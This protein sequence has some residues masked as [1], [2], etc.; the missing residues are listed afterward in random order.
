MEMGNAPTRTVRSPTCMVPGRDRTPT[1]PRVDSRPISWRHSHRKFCAPP[2][3]WKPT[4]SAPVRPRMIAA[5]HGICMNSSTGGNGMCRK[6]PMRRSGLS[7]RSIAGDQLQLVVLD[8]DR[9]ARR[10][11]LGAGLREPLVHLHVAVPPGPV[12]HRALDDVVV[13]RPERRVGEALVV[14][15]D[16]V[17][18]QRDGVQHEAVVVELLDV[19][20][21]HARPA[22]PRALA[23]PE[24]RL[25]R[26]HQPARAG[27]PAA[28]SVGRAFEVHR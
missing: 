25:E 20:V 23:R 4:R 12:E 15:A 6:K 26:R 22:D 8:P 21:G 10:G 24:E 2:G 18:A 17:G 9:R 3:R 5:R 14:V 16:L 13:E 27:R 19:D 28:F 1:A 11:D 7:S